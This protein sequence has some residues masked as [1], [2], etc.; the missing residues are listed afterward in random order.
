[1]IVTFAALNPL[2]MVTGVSEKKSR[3]S[4]QP[5]LAGMVGEHEQ[6]LE[7]PPTAALVK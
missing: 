3:C 5:H 4:H 2:A 6:L 7:L 1:V